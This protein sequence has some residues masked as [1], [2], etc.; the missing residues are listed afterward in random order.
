MAYLDFRSLGKVA[1]TCKYGGAPFINITVEHRMTGHNH[2]TSNK[3]PWVGGGGGGGGE[4]VF[5]LEINLLYGRA[6]I[7]DLAMTTLVGWIIALRPQKLVS[8]G[9][10]AQDVHLDFH[11]ASVLWLWPRST[12]FKTPCALQ[13]C[14]YRSVREPFYK[15]RPCMQSV[16]SECH[17]LCPFTS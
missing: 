11:T 2:Q 6:L 17:M 16:T 5:V 3:Q 7:K 1:Q 8:L 4:W 15:T 13:F 12:S 14:S 9:T 10:G